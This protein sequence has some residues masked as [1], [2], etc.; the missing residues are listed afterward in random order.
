VSSTPARIASTLL[1]CPFSRTLAGARKRDL[2]ADAPRQI[3]RVSPFHLPIGGEQE[4]G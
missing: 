2:R 3:P 1:T 4:V